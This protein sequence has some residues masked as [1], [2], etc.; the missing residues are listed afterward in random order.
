M[1]CRSFQSLVYLLLAIYPSIVLTSPLYRSFIQRRQ[2]LDGTAKSGGVA[3]KPPGSD[4]SFN[5]N[6][7]VTSSHSPMT[8]ATTSLA[9]GNLQ[10]RA[11][12]DTVSP[13]SKSKAGLIAS[14]VAPTGI[15]GIIGSV[16]GA[17]LYKKNQAGSTTSSA[18]GFLSSLFSGNSNAAKENKRADNH[19]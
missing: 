4:K 13:T 6:A 16:V 14:I 2:L 9:N 15:L 5:N 8:S 18:G 10:D 7:A 11:V 1:P 12:K 17:F 3:P 19:S